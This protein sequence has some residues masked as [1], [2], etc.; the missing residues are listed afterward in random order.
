MVVLPPISNSGAG[1]V[2]LVVA[3]NYPA[4]G[5]GFDENAD[6]GTA[7]RGKPRLESIGLIR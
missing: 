4:A 7:I 2:G 1:R 6:P 5:P 3:Q